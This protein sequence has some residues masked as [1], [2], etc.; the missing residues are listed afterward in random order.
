[1]RKKR[2]AIP[3]ERDTSVTLK[4]LNKFPKFNPAF[5][6]GDDENRI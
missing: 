2:E 3:I 6:L 4:D 5:K 1:M